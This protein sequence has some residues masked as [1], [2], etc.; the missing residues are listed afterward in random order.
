MLFDL[1][2]PLLKGIVLAMKVSCG[3]V[4]PNLPFLQHIFLNWSADLSC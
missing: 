2:V 4:F 3:L 1:K